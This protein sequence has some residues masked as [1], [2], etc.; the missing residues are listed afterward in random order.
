MK[1]SI[2]RNKFLNTLLHVQNIVEKRNTI[3]I[4]SNILVTTNQSNIIISATDM[5]MTITETIECSI[6]EEGSFTTPAHI[7]YEIVKKIS[8]GSQI[9]LISNDGNKLSVRSGKSKFTL[10]CLPENEFPKIDNQSLEN[11]FF[12][13]PQKLRDLIDKTKFAMSTEEARYY[14]N[15]IYLHS[16]ELE[17]KKKFRAVATDG[18]RLAKV[19]N[20]MPT[21]T[22]NIP[23]V[24]VPKKT[25]NEI[26]K[27]IDDIDHDVQISLN[28]SKIIFTIN[29][30]VISS[31]LIDGSFPD[32]EKVIPLNNDKEFS[33]KKEIMYN[34]VDRVSTMS[35]EKSKSV[36]LTILN[37]MISLSSNSADIGSGAEDI[38]IEYSGSDIEIG[39]NAKYLLEIINQIKGEKIIFKLF[40]SSSPTIIQ[41]QKN[42][43]TL[44]ILM[45]MRV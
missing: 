38:D 11:E 27:L 24:I 44:Y 42:V 6:I 28:E 37:N 25:I 23:G 15:G 14:L 16:V 34:A 31:K 2:E 35:S 29:K 32:Y 45:P 20:D 3:P 40:D 33:V 19:E 43:D 5:D 26:R 36:K 13:N 30:I 12:I 9:E 8:E 1:I 21:G 17:G 22:D 10:P 39:Y 18:H 4:L 7:L 41:D